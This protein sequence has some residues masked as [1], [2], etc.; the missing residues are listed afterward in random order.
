MWARFKKDSNWETAKQLRDAHPLLDPEQPNDWEKH[1]VLGCWEGS[2]LKAISIHAFWGCPQQNDIARATWYILRKKTSLYNLIY[3]AQVQKMPYTHSDDNC[4][5]LGLYVT[6]KRVYSLVIIVPNELK[7]GK[8]NKPEPTFI[9]S[10]ICEFTMHVGL[11][12]C[13]R[14]SLSKQ[15]NKIMHDSTLWLTR[16]TL[17][18]NHDAHTPQ[19]M[20]LDVFFFL[21]YEAMLFESLLIKNTRPCNWAWPCNFVRWASS[22]WDF[23]RWI[24][25]IQ[26][27]SVVRDLKKRCM[28]RVPSCLPSFR[29]DGI[30]WNTYQLP[31]NI[32]MDL[33]KMSNSV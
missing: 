24:S 3:K 30:W 13:E 6:P 29:N 27:R 26:Q 11:D 7:S 31:R 18:R 5:H 4:I 15:P 32:C 1:V 25:K 2:M 28:K 14:T 21:H 17:N 12:N 16:S 10:R 23:S 20:L 9:M 33:E 22:S 8:F 19:Q